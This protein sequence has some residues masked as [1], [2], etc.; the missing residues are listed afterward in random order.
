[1][2]KIWE[3]R[4]IGSMLDMSRFSIEEKQAVDQQ[5]MMGM[6]DQQGWLQKR[7]MGVWGKLI[8][9]SHITPYDL[10]RLVRYAVSRSDKFHPRGFVRNRLRDRDWHKY[11]LPK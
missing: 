11:D 10:D 5:T 1:M 7:W 2:E 9:D 4:K 6:I 8:K 3:N